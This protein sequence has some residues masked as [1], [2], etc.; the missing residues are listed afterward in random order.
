MSI[1]HER[2]VVRDGRWPATHLAA[3]KLRRKLVSW[4]ALLVFIS[5]GALAAEGVTLTAPAEAVVGSEIRVGYSGAANPRDFIT[6]VAAGESEGK[7]KAYQYARQSPVTLTVPSVPG[8]YEIRYL[9]AASP[10]ATRAHLALTVTDTSATLTAP[11][12]VEAGATFE[13]RWTGPDNVRD[14]ISIVAADAAEGTYESGYRYTNQGAVL[15]FTA[16]DQGGAYE[17]RYMMAESPFRTLGRKAFTVKGTEAS[18][19]APAEVS[20]GAAFTFTWSGPDNAQDF[21]T[22]TPTAAADKDYGAYV[23]TREGSPASLAAPDDPGDYEVRYLTG[24][25]YTVLARVPMKVMPVSASVSGPQTVEASSVALVTWTGPDNVRDYIIIVPAGAASS[26]GGHYAYTSR[27]PELRIETPEE[28]GNYEIRYMTGG[29]SR[30]LDSQPVTVTPRPIPGSL[31]VVDGSNRTAAD[32]SNASTLAGGSVVVIL[33]ASGS[34]LQKLGQSRRIDIAKQALEQLVTKDLP[35]EVQFSLRVFGH[36][37]KD[38]CR[39]DVE[40]PFAPLNR[41]QAAAKVA[42]ITAMNLARTPIA[43]TLSLAAADLAAQPGPHLI[44]LLTDGEETCDGDPAKVIQAMTAGG[45]DV[46][47]NIIGFAID[48]LMLRET[49]R[50]WARLGHGQYIDAQ[51]AA[52]LMAGMSQAVES[53]FQVLTAKGELI[54]SGAVNGPA[55]ELPAGTYTVQSTMQSH[56]VPVTIKPDDEAVITLDGN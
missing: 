41:A 19:T 52:Q 29:S 33:D 14:F 43:A 53:S 17:L 50:D 24:Q 20:A 55:I 7:Y 45:L 28:P 8:N 4:S 39:T 31:R 2:A 26:V 46:R 10:Y 23:Y 49:F 34:M 22:I 54:A 15:K 1:L 47:V 48:E 9:D 27:G 16:P 12:E 21:I 25:T 40:I 32:S 5:G 6:I 13:V 18:I 3:R 38:S 30:M 56:P 44:I 37:E 36:K 51:D 42:S 11:D 35:T